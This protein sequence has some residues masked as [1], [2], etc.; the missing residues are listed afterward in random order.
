MYNYNYKVYDY[1]YEDHA[2]NNR[3]GVPAEIS[4]VTY[5]SLPGRG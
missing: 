1:D 3:C 4:R 5:V 2:N